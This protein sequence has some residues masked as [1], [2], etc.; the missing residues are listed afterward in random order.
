M[1][2]RSLWGKTYAHNSVSVS[3][4]F[5]GDRH[6]IAIVG[7]MGLCR[8]QAGLIWGTSE[9]RKDTGLHLEIQRHMGRLGESV[10]TTLVAFPIKPLSNYD[11]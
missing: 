3:Q 7:C 8:E 1:G 5:Q 10:R 4:G 11:T 2:D 6:R 9:I